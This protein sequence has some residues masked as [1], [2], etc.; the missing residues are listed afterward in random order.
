M[1]L[2]GSEGLEA[3]RLPDM[4]R[5]EG[6]EYVPDVGEFT[7]ESFH[8]LLR[9]RSRDGRHCVLKLQWSDAMALFLLARSQ[10]S[11]ED[12]HC[13]WM[14]PAVR[15]RLREVYRLDLPRP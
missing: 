9:Y 8:L 4:D 10:L 11:H 13:G 6:I 14:T 7:Q 2:H 12:E 3:E 5:I 1:A 15:K